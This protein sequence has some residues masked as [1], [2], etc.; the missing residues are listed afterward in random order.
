MRTRSKSKF[1]ALLLAISLT[2]G[3]VWVPAL[4]ASET[5]ANETGTS[6]VDD[7][8]YFG[9][10]FTPANPIE[11]TSVEFY[12]RSA[13]SMWNARD[14]RVSIQ[15]TGGT[16][17]GTSATT[18]VSTSKGGGWNTFSFDTP[19]QL[20]AG[21]QYYAVVSYASRDLDYWYSSTSLYTGG[22]RLTISNGSS[23]SSASG[24]LRFRIQNTIIGEVTVTFDKNGGDTDAVPSSITTDFNTTVTLPE[25]PTRDGY[26]FN[27]WNTAANGYGDAF[28][29]STPVTGNLTVYAQWIDTSILPDGSIVIGKTTN[30]FDTYSMTDSFDLLSKMADHRKTDVTLTVEAVPLHKPIDLVIVLDIS[31]SMDDSPTKFADMKTAAKTLA[32]RVIENHPL[33]RVSVVRYGTDAYAYNFGSSAGWSFFNDI[34]GGSGRSYFTHNLTSVNAVIDGLSISG[35]NDGGT[36]TEGGFLAADNVMELEG[37][38]DAEFL[39]EAATTGQRV[40]AFM[41]DGVPTF[42]YDGTTATRDGDGTQSSAA[43]LNEAIAAGVAARTHSKA[44]TNGSVKIF[45][46]GLIEGLST[47]Q[48]TVARFLLRDQAHVDSISWSSGTI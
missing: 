17:L 48:T 47:F 13:S 43:E 38:T 28:T 29:A 33:S 40:I 24:D 41:T 2:L 45:T 37:R 32:M 11:V 46:V 12:M 34:S 1:L 6:R 15:T 22:T 35:G 9:Q 3:L 14:V 5:I 44:G 8:D 4:A 21:T 26:L 7:V 30:P 20:A 19:V 39:A 18:S 27:G 25:P 23:W 16:V 36:N 42:R 31:N 10:S